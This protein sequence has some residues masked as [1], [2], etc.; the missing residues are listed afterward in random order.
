MTALRRPAGGARRERESQIVLGLDP[1]PARLW[2]R[3]RGARR[4][5]DGRRPSAPPPRSSRHCRALIDARRPGLRRGQA[6][7][8]LLRAAR[9]ARL[10]GA[11]SASSRTRASAGPARARRRQARRRR[12]HRRR[13]RPGAGRRD[14]DA[15][16][17]RS[18]GSAPTPSPSTRCSGAT[19]S[20]RSSTRRAAA[21]AGRVRARAHVATRARADVEDLA[22]AGGEPRV[23]APR[24]AR[25]RARRAPG[26][27]AGCAT[28][29]PW[30]ARPRPSTS[31][32][33]RELMPRAPF[34]LPGVG[35]Q[36]GRVEDLAPAFAPGRAGGLVTASRSIVARPRA[37]RRRPGRRPPARG[38]APARAGLVAWADRTPAPRPMLRSAHGRIVDV[39]ASARW[40]APVALIAV[41]GGGVRRRRQHAAQGRQR[42]AGSDAAPQSTTTEGARRARPRRR[43][44]AAA[45]TS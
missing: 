33:L 36:G 37:A 26:P 38:R 43:A 23:G 19:R 31:P 18:P 29:A 25:R 13:L 7:A 44:S 3:G 9:R 30:S 41:R 4:R 17:R 34:L 42:V 1:D 40:L 45:P 5:A 6:A 8:R 2:P 16:R 39:A 35:A 32:A 15:V 14:A 12:R 22:A 28:S 24:A 20:S 21:G 27:A 11:R 10:G